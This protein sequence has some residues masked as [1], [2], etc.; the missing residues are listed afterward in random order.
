MP[1]ILFVIVANIEFYGQSSLD[2]ILDGQYSSEQLEEDLEVLQNGLEKLHPGLY[3]YTS[4]DS[5][6][7]LFNKARGQIRAQKS[8]L[9][10]YRIISAILAKV[11]C[12]HTVAAPQSETLNKLMANGR[13]FPL[14]LQWE[15]ESLNAYVAADFSFGADLEPGTRII[16]INNRSVAEIYDSLVPFFSSDG[17]ILTNKHSRLQVGV[18][19]Q[20]WYHLLIDRSEEFVVIME[21]TDGRILERKYDATTFREWG[22]NHRKYRKSKNPMI[23]EYMAHYVK[24]EQKN[25]TEPIRYRQLSERIGLLKVGN[26]NSDRFEKR[27]SEAFQKIKKENVEHLIVDIRNN[28]GGSDVL[29][30]YLFTHFID[31]PTVYFDSLYT[32]SGISDT[33]F[34]YRYTD[35]NQEWYQ[36][37][38]R[39]VDKMAK[40]G[41]AT[42]PEVNKGLKIQFPRNNRFK[43]E[44]YILMNGRSASTTA[45]FTAA[46]HINNLATF[47]GEESGGAYH[48]GNGG[49]FAEL[50][51]PNSKIVVNIPLVKYVM[52]SKEPNFIGRGTLPDFDVTSSMKDYLNLSDPQLNFALELIRKRFNE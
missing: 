1:I 48:G 17:D 25:R 16:K 43:G 47:I 52:N 49:D 22:K 14:K 34:L 26:F 9:E 31:K 46:M 42:K 6:K 4:K 7:A 39:L 8:Y 41:F 24:I 23:R 36:H 11:K 40:G 32:S 38:L 33:T 30:R 13:F 20:F 12:Q 45:E 18:D 21:K 35:K 44:V 28:G 10:L 27:I 2:S 19:F 5:L 15:F 51:L 3:R 37:N 29:G 50:K